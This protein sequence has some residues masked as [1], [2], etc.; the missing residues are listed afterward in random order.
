MFGFYFPLHF[1]LV[2]VYM[3]IAVGNHE[4]LQH[5]QNQST[6]SYT[7]QLDDIMDLSTV[8]Q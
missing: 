3:Y 1:S 4:Q 8:L 6:V 2:Y 7:Q 5:L